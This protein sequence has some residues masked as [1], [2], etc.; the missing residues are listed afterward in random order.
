MRGLSELVLFTG[1]ATGRAI[2]QLPSDLERLIGSYLLPVR[3]EGVVIKT[4]AKAVAA[5]KISQG[6]DRF[7]EEV[8]RR[9]WLDERDVEY[10]Q[11]LQEAELP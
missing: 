1:T 7:L 2:P 5:V 11:S 10:R 6:V 9:R 3:P 4:L 8:E